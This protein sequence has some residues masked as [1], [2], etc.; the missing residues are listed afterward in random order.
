[1]D[2]EPHWQ[3][4]K[5]LGIHASQDAEPDELDKILSAEAA[6]RNER[7]SRSVESLESSIISALAVHIGDAD[8]ALQL[9]HHT[10]H[11]DTPYHEV[12]LSPE[13]SNAEMK[14]LEQRISDLGK[15][16]AGLNMEVLHRQDTK[17]EH[18]VERWSR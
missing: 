9:L 8:M 6:E 13:D 11:A 17:K 5:S 10:L 2:I 18:F 12:H 3:L 7:L 15:G 16:M 1:M 14:L 4:F